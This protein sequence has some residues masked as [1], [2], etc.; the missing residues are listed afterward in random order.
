[1]ILCANNKVAIL[2]MD[3]NMPIMDGYAATRMV[4]SRRPDI[5]VIAITAYAL[6]TDKSKATE[7]GCDGI[8]SKPLDQMI[9]LGELKKYL[10]SD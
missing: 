2:E 6:S 3:L 10:L 9:L 4:K 8:I 1:L 7:A 5:P